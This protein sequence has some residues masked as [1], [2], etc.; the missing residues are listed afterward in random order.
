VPNDQVA[1]NVSVK[2]NGQTSNQV[3][4]T[5]QLSPTIYSYVYTPTVT[6]LAILGAGLQG[7]VSVVLGGP[8]PSTIIPTSISNDGTSIQVDNV[9]ASCIVS[10]ATITVNAV[11]PWVSN[12][13]T[14]Q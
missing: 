2:S 13:I 6:H 1:V 4:V 5:Y 9:G 8:C 10:G 3:P 7:S 11:P 12:T 14:V